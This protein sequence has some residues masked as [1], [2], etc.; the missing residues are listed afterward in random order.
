MK[1][2]SGNKRLNQITLLVDKEWNHCTTTDV[3]CFFFSFLTDRELELRELRKM[4]LFSQAE[5][6]SLTD[7]MEELKVQF[8]FICIDIFLSLLV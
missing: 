3:D 4:V 2:L 7:E 5:N 6:H 8:D 1:I